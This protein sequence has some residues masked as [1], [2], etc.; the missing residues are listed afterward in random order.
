[1]TELMGSA[2]WGAFNPVFLKQ[3]VNAITA[4][5]VGHIIPHGTFTQR[6]LSGNPWM[7]D[8]YNEN[9]IFPWMHLWNGFAARAIKRSAQWHDSHTTALRSVARL[10]VFSTMSGFVGRSR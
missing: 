5:G 9:P 3:S 2:G 7:P 4:W 8:F 1:M 6:K 10:S